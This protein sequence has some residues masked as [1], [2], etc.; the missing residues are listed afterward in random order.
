V[1]RHRVGWRWPHA[2][3]TLAQ[4]CFLLVAA[5]LLTNKY[6]A[7]STHCWLVPLAMLGHSPRWKLLVA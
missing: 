1:P 3:A 2:Q 6:G 7:R 5:F 4:L